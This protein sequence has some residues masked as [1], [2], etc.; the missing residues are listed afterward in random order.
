MMENTLRERYIE[1]RRGIR[2]VI[3]ER[4]YLYK[5]TS[6]SIHSMIRSILTDTCSYSRCWKQAFPTSYSYFGM[7]N[8]EEREGIWYYP[9]QVSR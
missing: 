5:I 2:D 6:V 9:Y 4:M 7:E 3:Y 1:G 8:N